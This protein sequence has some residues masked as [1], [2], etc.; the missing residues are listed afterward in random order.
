AHAAGVSPILCLTKADLASGDDLVAMY[1]Q[2]GIPVTTSQP[3]ADLAE[4]H[5]LLRGKV[6][7]LVGHSGVGKS[8]LINALVPGG[9]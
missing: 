2:L 6:S 9:N 7:V 3:G 8:T 1:S 5:Q 4:L